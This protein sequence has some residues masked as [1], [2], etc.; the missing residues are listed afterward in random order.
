MLS[1]LI[2]VAV[3][4]GLGAALG[5]FGQCTSGACPLTSTW[6]RG[7]LYGATLGLMFHLA[8]GRTTAGSPT[9]AN[10]TNVVQITP[11]AFEKEVLQSTTP[12]VVDFYAP[13]CGPCKLLAPRLEKVA[14]AYAGRVKVL[15]VNV[16]TAAELAGR[17]EVRGV[18]ALMVFSQGRVTHA[19]VGLQTESELQ[20]LFE[21]ALKGG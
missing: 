13:W 19:T 7:A 8:T 4:A 14:A 17:Y 12:V 5:T 9:A 2:S 6:W 15:K 10:S 21:R 1:L 11:A 16:D 20:G 18:P 3:G